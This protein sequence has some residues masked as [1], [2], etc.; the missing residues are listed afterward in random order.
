MFPGL[1]GINPAQMQKMMQQMG[2]K[3]DKV[4][5]KKVVFEMQDGKK[6]EI[7]SP[8]I[9]KMTIQG[10]ETYQVIGS[11]KEVAETK[12]LFSEDDI[13]LVQEKTNCSKEMAK[14]ELEK[15]K[16]DI[17]EAILNLSK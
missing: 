14:K 11:A 9:T 6:L 10:T 3:T 12:L 8:E 17:A 1:G 5:A 16:G 7:E 2:I 13:Q 15:T 4:D